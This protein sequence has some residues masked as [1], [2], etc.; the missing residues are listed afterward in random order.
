MVS[1]CT[2]EIARRDMKL[3]TAYFACTFG[4]RNVWTSC[5]DKEF[6][7]L[8]TKTMHEACRDFIES[9]RV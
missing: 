1:S 7:L 4:L 8:N 2:R 6:K 5:L 3:Q 9:H